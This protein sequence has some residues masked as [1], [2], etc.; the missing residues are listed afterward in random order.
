MSVDALLATLEIAGVSLSVEGGAL[1]YRT[2]GPPL[3]PNLR[4]AISAQREQLIRR[5]AP[6]ADD[7]FPLTPLQ[8]A[9]WIGE[10]PGY[11]LSVPA[12]IHQEFAIARLDAARLRVALAAMI[13]RHDML[14]VRFTEDGF[15][16]I[17]TERLSDSLPVPMD[18]ID[19]SRATPETAES[20]LAALRQ[21]I[22][23]RLPPLECGPPFY[24]TL[25][26]LPD[27][28]RLFLAFRLIAFDGPAVDL[29]YR[30][31]G[32]QYEGEALPPAEQDGFRAWLLARL[33]NATVR[34][35]ALEYWRNRLDTLP[36]APDFPAGP[37]AGTRVGGFV[38]ITGRLAG[39]HWQDIEE[40][41]RSMGVSVNAVLSTAFADTLRLWSRTKDFTLNVL[42]SGR[43]LDRT[44][45]CIG[46]FS[47][48]LLLAQPDLS[49]TFLDRVRATQ[50]QLH[51]DMAH[52]AI[53][54]VEVIREL[55]RR[56][57][58]T[59]QPLMPV[60]FSSF[61]GLQQR[62]EGV[63]SP[64]PGW[65]LVGGSMNTPQVLLDHQVFLDGGDLAFNFDYMEHAYP[66]GMVAAIEAQYR[67]YLLS[68]A[69]QLDRW[70]ADAVLPL[71][72]GQ[73]HERALSNSTEITLPTGTLHGFVLNVCTRHGDRLAV[74]S[75]GQELTFQAVADLSHAIAA[76]LI[77]RGVEPGACVGILLAKGWRQVVAAI[78]IV[79]AG[80]AYVPLDVK[81]PPARLEQIT[82]H[83]DIRILVTDAP[84]LA[85][86][87][88]SCVEVPPVG[89]KGTAALPDVAP[90]QDA[91]VIFTSGST[92]QPKGVVISHA[93]AVN[94][95]QDVL[96]RF[97]VT[98]R[99]RG[100]AISALNFDLSVFDIFGILAAGGTLVMPAQAVMPDPGLLATH[101]RRDGVTIWNSVP[102]LMEMILDWLGTSAPEALRG[103]KVVMLSGD[104]I[105]LSLPDRIRSACPDAT[106]YSLGGATEASIWSNFHPVGK[107]EESW[108]SIPYGKALANQSL[109][110]LD[111]R[112]RP[113]PVWVP[114][115]LYIGGLGLA[116][117][118][119]GAPDQTA[120]S[121]VVHPD[122]GKRLYRTGDLARY[123][124]G[125]IVEFL[126]REDF[127]VKLRG[128]RIE[129]GEIDA[130]LLV[131]S[132]VE[133]AVTV[134]VRDRAGKPIGLQSHVV[135][136]KNARPDVAALTAH[137]AA[138]L[139]SYMVPGQISVIE[140]IP[141]TA[142]GKV[143]RA[144]LEAI[145]G[146]RET[147]EG[148]AV[149]P[150][151]KTE[152]RLLVAWQRL[153]DRDD[154]GITD[155]FFALGG[156]SLTAV[157]LIVE[158]ERIFG[159]R[160]P[161]STLLQHGTIAAQATLLRNQGQKDSFS[162]L[163]PIR[164][165]AGSPA[166]Y[167]VHP[168]GGSVLCYRDLAE[169]LTG[170]SV[171]ALQAEEDWRPS[172]VGEMAERYTRAILERHRGGPVALG[173]WSMGGVIALEMAYQ[174]AE[175][176]IE[177]AGLWLIDSW[178]GVP[179]S[180]YVHDHGSALMSFAR[181]FAGNGQI[182]DPIAFDTIGSVTET[183]RLDRII[184]FL[185]DGKDTNELEVWKNL[186]RR[187][188]LHNYN[189]KLLSK[190][191]V[192]QVD[193][194]V[195][196]FQSTIDMGYNFPGLTRVP[197]IPITKKIKI[198]TMPIEGNHFS[199]LQPPL[200]LK[201]AKF[202]ANASVNAG[203][204]T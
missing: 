120:R 130:T 60:V 123:R 77:A 174:F 196:Y 78:G 105:P 119:L 111:H 26:R 63:S 133:S 58:T 50:K 127:Q 51:T 138:S 169:A 20:E 159:V 172:D 101:I 171:L 104:W 48:T 160:L 202:I 177:I 76:D 110:V 23:R 199:I 191:I 178:T 144:A 168:V 204:Y 115:D 109:H 97:S 193:C 11:R 99:D 7:P 125:G 65:R 95:I 84:D 121:F 201:L 163:V 139:P 79:R 13:A 88:L 147:A 96:R 134:V 1:R 128:F 188:E 40:R 92:G 90:E 57:G 38:R 16:Q 64:I 124:P 140:T 46:N 49:G 53:S 81:L 86:P 141:L 34:C 4:T 112:M 173:G 33:G 54:G 187:F 24:C 75:D 148:T 41:A 182:I 113:T 80:A 42:V 153:L 56:T 117:E 150:G 6:H 135:L 192:K 19:L 98:S 129:L 142:N 162:E 170:R 189:Y 71:L 184:S 203:H 107:Q 45:N 93:A 91:Y 167:L 116:R 25:V 5:L 94:T 31:L 73:L 118:Y 154:L 146:C 61:I 2:S 100:L 149:K 87:R 8:Q 181:D 194:E 17:P 190:H 59:D 30:E 89:T 186:M 158:I 32:S 18:V 131:H 106:L 195:V 43:P 176:G 122:T 68:L 70:N 175:R 151:D 72:P 14:R 74:I 15:Q 22:R 29:F 35:K 102:A 27:Q 85:P 62:K 114:G 12:H 136:A 67:E 52:S 137:L 157:R 143:D 152:C 183:E 37:R 103:L 55:Q 3:P 132:D 126:G 156:N 82:A 108:S 10:Q 200:S 180:N 69:T 66:E 198:H 164:I 179:D 44:A 39:P 155:D 145:A 21:D 165:E 36:P 83:A 47:T 9:Y 197:E 166:V 185:R 161:L 28:D